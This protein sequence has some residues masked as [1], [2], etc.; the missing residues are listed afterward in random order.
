MEAVLG[1]RVRV[2]TPKGSVSVSIPPGTSSGKTLRL[3][4]KGADGNDW[5]VR[6]EIGVPKTVDEES[7]RLIEQ[8]GELNPL[9]P[10]SE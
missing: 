7:R 5:F 9:D 2:D 10:E 1:G 4:G 8:F 3:K 6:V